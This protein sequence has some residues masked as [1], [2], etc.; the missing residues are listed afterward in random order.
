MRLHDGSRATNASKNMSVF[1]PHFNWVYNNHLATDPTLIEQVPQCH[2]LWELGN[3]ISR[4]EFSKAATKLKNAK[5][6]GLTGVPPEAFKAIS[7]ANLCH[8]YNHVNDFF[9]GNTDHK[10]WHC[11]QCVPVPKSS[12]LSEDPNK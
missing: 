7:P 10:Q 8:V 1:S 5:A 2:T 11:S 4:E 9:L 6:P 3:P 12:D